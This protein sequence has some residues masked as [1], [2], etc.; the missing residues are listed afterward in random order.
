MRETPSLTRGEGD[1]APILKA[2]SNVGIWNS[3]TIDGGK[4]LDPIEA[5]KPAATKAAGGGRATKQAKIEP[6]KSEPEPDPGA[7]TSLT[8]PGEPAMNN[9]NYVDRVRGTEA[10]G[11]LL[12]HLL[13][14]PHRP[15]ADASR[16]AG[17]RQSEQASPTPEPSPLAPGLLA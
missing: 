4:L 12:V 7:S 9:M 8:K 10:L 14:G 3:S 16:G 15:S 11:D 6:V 1:G 5:G 17:R 13:S 2:P